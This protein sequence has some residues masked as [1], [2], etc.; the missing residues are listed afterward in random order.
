MKKYEIQPIC[1]SCLENILSF[2]VA[3]G[4]EVFEVTKFGPSQIPY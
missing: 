1:I 2:L 4:F 3:E